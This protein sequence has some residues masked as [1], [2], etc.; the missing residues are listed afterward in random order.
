M[1]GRRIWSQFK[2]DVQGFGLSAAKCK[3]RAGVRQ[4]EVFEFEFHRVGSRRDVV[5]SVFSGAI[6]L[7]TP[8]R[9]WSRRF[10]GHRCGWQRATL[11]ISYLAAQHR[12]GLRGRRRLLESKE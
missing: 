1:L 4:K 11:S 10:Q 2:H 5:E 7:G 8:R 9:S 12:C 3:A 6:H